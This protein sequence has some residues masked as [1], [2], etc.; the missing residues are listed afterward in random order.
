M[1]TIP[2]T[3]L[4]SWVRRS[5][6]C[7]AAQDAFTGAGCGAINIFGRGGSAKAPPPNKSKFKAKR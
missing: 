6:P 2:P 3:P 7:N 4:P 5:M 1:A